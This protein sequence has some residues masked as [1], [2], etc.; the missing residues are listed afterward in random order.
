MMFIYTC[1]NILGSLLIVGGLYAMLWGKH[2]EMKI[3]STAMESQSIEIVTTTTS[4]E[5]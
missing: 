2:K 3:S 1:D 4:E 5:K